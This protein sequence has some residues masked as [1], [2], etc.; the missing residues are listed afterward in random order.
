MANRPNFDLIDGRFYSGDLGDVRDAYAWMRE[1]EPVY[2]DSANGITAAASY[3]AVIAAER[4][5]ALFSNSGG[6]RP[7]TGPLPQ[8]IDMD[9]PEHLT[10][11]RLVN[12]G[13]TKRKVEAKRDRIRQIC[14]QLIDAVCESG[15]ADFVADLAAPLPMAVIGDMLGVRPQERAVFLRWSDDLVKALGSNASPEQLQAMMAAYVDF[16]EYMT[17]TIR[18]RRS[19][20]ADDLIS[21][22]IHSEIDGEALSDQEIVNESLLILI[23]GDE[24]T[25]HVLSG[26]MEQLL[27]H[28]NQYRTLAA[29]PEMIPLA[30]EEMLRWSSPIKN[31]ARTLTRDTDFFGARLK[32]G[33]K[34]LLLFESANFDDAV[35]VDAPQFDIGRTP[36][37]HVAFGFGTH[38][39]LGNQLARLEG[40]IMFEQLFQRLPGME[41]ATDAP[42]PRR[43]AN[44]VS[45]I[46][47]MP[48]RFPLAN[49][50]PG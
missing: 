15:E 31:M 45:G 6:I 29:D 9:D 36:N 24:T 30:M 46:E 38:F 25:R 1:H 4:D 49:L 7:E 11:R 12:A 5:P 17:R 22:L 40:T 48:I 18:E 8:M 26:G 44:F 41:L 42:L 43:A 47:S 27:R 3:A 16:T 50:L 35:F 13:F 34:M 23:G 2:R 32:A 37:P 33:E 28:P 19:A 14:D 21:T 10:R 39:C 20:P